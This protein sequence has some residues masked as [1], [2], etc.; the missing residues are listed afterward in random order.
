[1]PPEPLRHR[2]AQ[3]SARPQRRHRGSQRVTIDRSD[4]MNAQVTERDDD[5]GFDAGW[6]SRQASAAASITGTNR[7]TTSLASSRAHRRQ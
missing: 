2:E 3:S 4:E 6:R 7:M 5:G 1:M